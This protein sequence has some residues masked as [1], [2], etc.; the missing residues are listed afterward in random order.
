MVTSVLV[1][2]ASVDWCRRWKLED[3]P[4]SVSFIRGHQLVVSSCM[5]SVRSKNGISTAAPIRKKN[6]A[7]PSTIL[8]VLEKWVVGRIQETYLVLLLDHT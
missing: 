4:D 3:G 8:F 5:E 6:T 1:V 7:V 2:A